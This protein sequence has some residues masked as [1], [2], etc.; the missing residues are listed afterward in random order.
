VVSRPR[1]GNAVRYARVIER[2]WSELLGKPIVLSPRD[3]ARIE[4]WC[5][6]GIPLEIVD[7]AMT[8]VTE[9]GTTDKSTRR[10]AELA[11]LVEDAWAVILDGRR[12]PR[13][14]VG[15][16][17]EADP[18]SLWRR[19]KEREPVGSP[20]AV[21]LEGFIDRFERGEDRHGLDA[22]LDHCLVETV[23]PALRDSVQREVDSDVEP[24]RG[25][26][27]AD[28]LEA[29]RRRACVDRLR[30]LLDLPRL[31]VTPKEA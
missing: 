27:P 5:A 9:R 11:P 3:W 20:L 7:E 29:T 14:E 23:D 10:L 26:I 6:L 1:T 21:L 12:A 13:H 28:R 25:R 19:R 18:L 31:A 16:S 2:R 22:E 15:P 24:F 17:V 4:H 8:A 30:R